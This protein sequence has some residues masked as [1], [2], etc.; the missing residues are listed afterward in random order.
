MAGPVAGR[1]RKGFGAN[2]KQIILDSVGCNLGVEGR[3]NA[4]IKRAFGYFSC[5]YNLVFMRNGDIAAYAGLRVCDIDA[6][7]VNHPIKAKKFLNRAKSGY[8]KNDRQASTTGVLNS[9]VMRLPNCS[10]LIR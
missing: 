4:P 7:I 3:H 10:R 8:Y 2:E 5:E 6:L 9:D 1:L